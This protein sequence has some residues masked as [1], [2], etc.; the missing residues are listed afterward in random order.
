MRILHVLYF[1][2][3]SDEIEEDK[4]NFDCILGKKFSV[5]NFK[6]SKII[7]HHLY[8]FLL[9]TFLNKAFNV[10]YVYLILTGIVRIMQAQ[11]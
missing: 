5:Q 11:S 7:K 10:E 9:N 8:D 6:F 1:D 4:M 3:V 2:S